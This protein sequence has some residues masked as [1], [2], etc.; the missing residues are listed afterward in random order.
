MSHLAKSFTLLPLAGLVLAAC[1]SRAA[2][3]YY[4]PLPPPP[5]RAFGVIGRSPGPGFVWLDGYHDWYGNRY[6]W[7]PGRWVRPPRASAVWVPGRWAP[8]GRNHVWVRGYW[9]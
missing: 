6:V 1:S 3:G 8:R 7:V 2:V 5:P 4:R 9:R